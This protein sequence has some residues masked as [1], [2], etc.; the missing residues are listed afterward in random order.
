MAA[1]ADQM[2]G[3]WVAFARNGNPNHKRIPHWPAF[4]TS[5]RATMIWNTPSRVVNDPY[6]DERLAL[7]AIQSARA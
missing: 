7:A 1:L 2:S 6:R 5:Q 4:N 3:A